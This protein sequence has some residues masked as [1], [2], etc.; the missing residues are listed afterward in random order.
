MTSEELKLR[1]KKFSLR[2]INLIESLPNSIS[3]K[4]IANQLIRSAT[5]VGANYRSACRSRSKAEFVSKIRIVEEE[6]DES[7]YWLEIIKESK[8]VREVRIADLI[9]EAMELTAIFT[10]IGKTSKINLKNSNSEIP[11]SKLEKNPKSEKC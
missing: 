6:A 10:S 3:G 4:V 2:V 5:S 9:K 1:T 8:L 7:L 11:N